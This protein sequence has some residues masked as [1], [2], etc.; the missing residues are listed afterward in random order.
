[1]YCCVCSI[2]L[3]IKLKLLMSISFHASPMDLNFK[4]RKLIAHSFFSLYFYVDS[5]NRSYNLSDIMCAVWP[6]KLCAKTLAPITSLPSKTWP[7]PNDSA[8]GENSNW[9]TQLDRNQDKNWVVER[10][11][12]EGGRERERECVCVC[13]WERERERGRERE[14]QRDGESRTGVCKCI[15]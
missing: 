10:A 13:V 7:E 2:D 3:F 5:C 1:M 11:R 12:S 8:P 4:I 6:C 14:R 9:I 15:T